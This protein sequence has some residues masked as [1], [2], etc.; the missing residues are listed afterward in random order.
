MEEKSHLYSEET[1]AIRGAI[2]EVYNVMG[3]GFIEPVYQEC[4][5]REFIKR[6]IPF[7]ARP[8][9]R[10]FYKDEPLFQ[11][12]KPDFVCY[13]KIIVEI[14]AVK[15]FLP[16]HMAQMINYLK[17]TTFRLGLLVNFAAEDKAAIKRMIR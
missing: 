10:L 11:S 8:Q 16:E 2:F 9:M 17:A 3:V 6:G 14:K 1:F 13:G 7:E 15:E 4:L 12:L 5:E